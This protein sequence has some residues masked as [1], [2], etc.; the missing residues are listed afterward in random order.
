MPRLL[1]QADPLHGDDVE[2][3]GWA[4]E[5]GIVINEHV[6]NVCRVQN[7]SVLSIAVTMSYD[8]MRPKYPT[9]IQNHPATGPLLLTRPVSTFYLGYRARQLN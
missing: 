7:V 6:F 8:L 9:E 2:Q 5:H 4:R 3:V 1:V